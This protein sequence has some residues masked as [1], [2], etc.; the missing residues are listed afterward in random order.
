MNPEIRPVL[1]SVL[2]TLTGLQV[3]WEEGRGGYIDPTKRA[4]VTL[5]TFGDIPLGRDERGQLFTPSRPAGTEVQEVVRGRR[6]VTLR[7]KVESFEQEDAKVSQEY[8]A[9]I[10][11]LW[12]AT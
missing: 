5:N 7:V 4:W 10:R 3:F 6:A 12:A 2:A 9:M 1:K 11:D 8:M